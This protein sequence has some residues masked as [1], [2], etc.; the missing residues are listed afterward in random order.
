MATKIEA[1]MSSWATTCK[2]GFTCASPTRSK[3]QSAVASMVTATFWPARRLS[4]EANAKAQ[5]T[6]GTAITYMLSA[7]FK[8]PPAK[9][10][11]VEAT[12]GIDCASATTA[13]TAKNPR[14]PR[15]SSK[16][17]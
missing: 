7:R 8:A 2:P 16:G 15:F 12:G 5:T 1:T 6:I 14:R 4:M 11:K 10:A 3:V 13:A 17:R 9:C